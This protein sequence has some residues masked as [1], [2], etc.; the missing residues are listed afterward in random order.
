[1]FKKIIKWLSYCNS[2]ESELAKQ[3]IFTVYTTHGSFT[4]LDKALTTHINTADDQQETI[5]RNSRQT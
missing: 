5:S 3:G 4:Y 1:M 2:I